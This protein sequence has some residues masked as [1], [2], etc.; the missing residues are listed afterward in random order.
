MFK[1]V[2]TVWS[3]F[4]GSEDKLERKCECVFPDTFRI[5]KANFPTYTLL[6]QRN[7]KVSFLTLSSLVVKCMVAAYWPKGWWFDPGRVN[8]NKPGQYSRVSCWSTII[9]MNRHVCQL[10][11]TDD[12][13]HMSNLSLSLWHFQDFQKMFSAFKGWSMLLVINTY[14]AYVC[15]QRKNLNVNVNVSFLTHSGFSKASFLSEEC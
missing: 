11:L 8:Q 14:G 4:S 12:T 10:W 2:F 3:H 7:M 6:L 15:L 13:I 9:H 5:L 1:K